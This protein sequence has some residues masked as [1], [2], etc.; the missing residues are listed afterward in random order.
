MK[1]TYKKKQG[2]TLIELVMVIVIVTLLSTIALPVYSSLKAKGQQAVCL[3]N[4]RIL[5]LGFN[6]YL[7]EHD[8]VWP[9]RPDGGAEEKDE[10]TWKWWLETL[11]PF[12]VQKKNW[13]CPADVENAAG[14]YDQEVK[15]IGSYIPTEFDELPNT[16]FKWKQPWI[17]ERG[18]YHGKNTGPH[19]VMPDGSII[20]GITMGVQ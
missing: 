9:Q 20:K 19:M 17:I 18:E 8:M 1:L 12:D 2:F 3:G 16:A 14:L 7:Q 15:F 11:K 10:L 4:L 6:S 5:H 13:I